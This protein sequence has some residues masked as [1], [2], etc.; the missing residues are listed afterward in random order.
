M[1][2]TPPPRGRR[3]AKLAERLAQDIVQ[4]ISSLGLVPG[5]RLPSEV[6]MAQE[7][8]VSRASLR[9]A[10]RILEV[11]GMISIRTGPGGGPV[12]SRLTSQDFARMAT[13]HFHAAGVTFRQLLKARLTLEPRMAELAAA[14]RTPEQVIALRANVREHRKAA[15]IHELVRYA[16][17]FHALVSDCAGDENRALSLMTLSLHGIF[18]PYQRQ[19]GSGDVMR[20]TIDVHSGISDAIEEGDPRRAAELMEKHMQES[21]ETFGQQHPTMIDSPVS[22]LSS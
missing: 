2:V 5:D 8:G 6:V 3:G 20:H 19:G 18:D 21:A 4:H 11:H 9:E 12:L 16:H 14:N 13:L 1:S 10:L 22:W 15:D 7:W 17:D